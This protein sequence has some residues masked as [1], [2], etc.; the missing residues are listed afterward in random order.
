MTK[1][2]SILKSRNITLLTKVHLVKAMVF[3]VVMYGCESWTIEKA[4]HRRT[5]AFELWYGEDSWESLGLRGNQTSQSQRKSV[6]NIHWKDRCWSSNTLATWCEEP[7]QWKW[8]WCWER[9]KAGREG[10]DREWDSW[11]ASRHDGREFEQIP[12]VYDGQGSLGCCSPW[13][14]KDWV[15]ELNWTDCLDVKKTKQNVDIF[16]EFILLKYFLAFY[17]VLHL[18]MK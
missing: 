2:D 16:S 4:E 13:G 18:Y 11:M 1:Q 14:R 17:F 9:L 3:P 7:T 15:S 5:D 10:D 6:L 8:P 12:G